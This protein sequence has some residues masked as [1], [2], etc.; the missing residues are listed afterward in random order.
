MRSCLIVSLVVASQVL[1]GSAAWAAPPQWIWSTADAAKKAAPG[2]VFFRKTFEVADPERGELE[3]SAD[4][5]YEL[6]VN[7]RNVG[8]GEG[9][10]QRTKYDIGPLL[11]KGSNL[12]AVRA[13]NAGADPAGLMVKATIKS[14]GKPAVEVVTDNTWK[15]ATQV[16]GRWAVNDFGDEK[17]AKAHALGE[18]G[19][20]GPWG[21]AGPVVV[22]KENIVPTGT[23]SQEKGH[24]QLRDG[25]RVV[26]LGGT[27]VERLQNDGYLETTLT[28]AL[29]HKNI[30]Y[31]NLGWSGDTVWGDSRGVFG[32]R[33]DGFKRLVSDVTLCKPTV[34][35][36]CYGQN[37]AYAG[38][39]GLADF[40]QG[41]NQLLDALEPTGARLVLLTPP[42]R[43]AVGPAADTASQYNHQLQQYT[44]V[45]R[46][47][48]GARGHAIADLFATLQQRAQSEGPSRPPLTDN[49][50]HLTPYGNWQIS[51]TVAR[52]IGVPAEPWQVEIDVKASTLEARGTAV[53]ELKH[54]G[55]GL[56][57]VATDRA[58][59]RTELSQADQPREDF[60]PYASQTLE[61]TGLEP[62]KY[63]VL[64]DGKQA[65][66]LEIDGRPALLTFNNPVL[67]ERQ[68]RLR[69]L[70]NEKNELF[71][72]RH[73]P[74][75]ET[76]LFLFRKHEQGNNA[77]EIPMFDPLVEEKEKEIAE[78]R[79]PLKQKYELKRVK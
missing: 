1:S 27:F 29:P 23:K 40:E 73:R 60:V 45:I 54:D 36:V 58:L 11:I 28:G 61:V 53:S 25:D 62:G 9:W 2:D 79:K 51:P 56:S 65:G 13:K 75:N 47:T 74:Q 33:A 14:K 77:V 63:E 5:S 35:V 4:N 71:F 31:R 52:L 44:E 37:E 76:Y 42:P 8:Y 46:D 24:F 64:V 78:L 67:L 10:H 69:K 32:S 39:K 12:I 41:L 20:V 30:T 57:F 59:P 26:L 15:Y 7:G 3:I 49:G 55:Q 68:A 34:I 21:A 18:Y 70:I 48:A 50:Q 43:E 38:E 6:F 22:A 72:H 19:K 17:W 16:T 66:E